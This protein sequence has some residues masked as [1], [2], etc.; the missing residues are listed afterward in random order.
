MMQKSA[1]LNAEI[2]L[3]FSKNGFS[4]ELKS[5][6]KSE[7]LRLLLRRALSYY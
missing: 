1:D 3:L 5:Q 2:F 6:K 4:S 7:T